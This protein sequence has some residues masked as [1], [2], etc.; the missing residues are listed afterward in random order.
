MSKQYTIAEI[1][2]VYA[3]AK[4]PIMGIKRIF[5]MIL[6]SNASRIKNAIS[7]VFSSSSSILW[8]RKDNCQKNPAMIKGITN[9][10]NFNEISEIYFFP[11]GRWDIKLKSEIYLYHFKYIFNK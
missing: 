8:V 9:G 10:L 3:V 4:T 6:I 1:A 2:A 5:T 11:S 7:N